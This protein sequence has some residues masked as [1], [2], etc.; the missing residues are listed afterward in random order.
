LNLFCG[1]ILTSLVIGSSTSF[2]NL[3][4]GSDFL[5]SAT[6]IKIL[7][8]TFLITSVSRV[9]KQILIAQANH[10][11]LSMAEAFGALI[12]AISAIWASTEYG[13]VGIAYCFLIG[14]FIS[15]FLLT[16]MIFSRKNSFP[17]RQ[18]IIRF[19]LACFIVILMG[20]YGDSVALILNL[21]WL[22]LVLFVSILLVI[23]SALCWLTMLSKDSRAFM[24]H[25]LLG[26]VQR[27]RSNR[28]L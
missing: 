6:I 16:L 20:I 7:A 24:I 18:T 15:S 4:L 9:C 26:L 10:A 1:T 11:L 12:S 25:S 28:A 27:L 21:S 17:L 23:T 14:Y 13:I 5:E 19:V 8:F 2:I 3:W 22:G